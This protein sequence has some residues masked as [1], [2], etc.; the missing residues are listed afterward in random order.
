MASI[1]CLFAI[2]TTFAHAGKCIIATD[3][4]GYKFMVLIGNQVLVRE[5]ILKEMHL[6][7]YKG[8]TVV[9]SFDDE[10][11][12]NVTMSGNGVIAY[13]TTVVDEAGVNNVYRYENGK[14]FPSQPIL[15]V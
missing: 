9:D 15:A 5:K 8:Y 6:N 11:P 10:T 13:V 3:F 2:P 12:T 4:E 7:D 14:R 1:V